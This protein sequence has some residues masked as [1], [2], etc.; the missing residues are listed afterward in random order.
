M[1]A[2]RQYALVFVPAAAEAAK[3]TALV[4]GA[5]CTEASKDKKTACRGSAGAE[6]QRAAAASCHGDPTEL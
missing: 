5:T 4:N 1:P 6:A 3:W 2:I